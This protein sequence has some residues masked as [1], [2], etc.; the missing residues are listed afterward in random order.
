MKTG[1]SLGLIAFCCLCLLFAL[2]FIDIQP[3]KVRDVPKAA[4]ILCIIGITT[5]GGARI[6]IQ[7]K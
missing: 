6:L 7:N 4:M 1:L 5:A 3:K 2:F